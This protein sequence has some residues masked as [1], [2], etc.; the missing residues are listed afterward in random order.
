MLIDD[1]I[2]TELATGGDLSQHLIEPD[3]ELLA[4]P[5]QISRTLARPPTRKPNVNDLARNHTGGG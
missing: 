3:R 4:G 1:P 5:V 2:A